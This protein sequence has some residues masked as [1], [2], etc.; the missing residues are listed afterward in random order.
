MICEKCGEE[1]RIGEW[2]FCPHGDVHFEV[3]AHEPIYYEH[4]S[5]DGETFTSNRE[6]RKFMD[7]HGI[8]EKENNPHR[9]RR[10]ARGATGKSLFFDMGHK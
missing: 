8:T 10:P 2:P 6:K 1:I 5:T 9:T 3:D 4:L 7:K